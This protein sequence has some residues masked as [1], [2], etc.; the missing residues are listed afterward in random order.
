MRRRVI[1]VFLVFVANI[2][3]LSLAYG[4]GPPLISGDFEGVGA[5]GNFSYR[6]AKNGIVIKYYSPS[7]KN[8]REYFVENYDECSMMGVYALKGVNQIVVDGSCPSQGGQIYRNVYEWN[9]NIGDWCL[10][11]EITGQR[12][13]VPDGVLFPSEQVARVSGCARL[14]GSGKYQYE[15]DGEVRSQISMELD[16][17]KSIIRSRQQVEKY[18]GSL[19]QYAVAELVAYIDGE[20]VE[21]INNIAFYLVEE[22]R[23]CEAVPVLSSIV[24]KFPDRVVAKLNLG[25]A[26]WGCAL[27]SQASEQYRAYMSQMKALG[28]SGLVPKRVAQRTGG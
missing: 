20:D 2:F 16:Q 8:T 24:S 12:E 27:R 11:R 3:A 23:P 28:K 7:K 9:K 17:F 4:S 19:P 10:V 6:D 25:D 21:Q 26:Y 5:Q 14:G 13:N 18:I 22:G 1:Y 15:S